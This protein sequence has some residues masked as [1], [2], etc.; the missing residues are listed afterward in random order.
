MPNADIVNITIAIAIIP[1][2]II[3]SFLYNTEIRYE[4]IEKLLEISPDHFE[5]AV[6]LNTGSEVTDIAS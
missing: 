5:K 6:L 2:N 4:F 1:I 3:Y